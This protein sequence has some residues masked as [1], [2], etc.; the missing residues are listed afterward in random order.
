MSLPYI[1]SDDKKEIYVFDGYISHLSEI[2]KEIT[3]NQIKILC[4]K[5]CEDIGSNFDFPNNPI[6]EITYKPI[7]STTVNHKFKKQNFSN[8]PEKLLILRLNMG[9]VIECC[10]MDNL[11]G[12]LKRLY[13]PTLYHW[14][15]DN[16]PLGLEELS[17]YVDNNFTPCLN[18]LP[19][20]LKE[21]RISSLNRR[22]E[23]S[24]NCDNLPNG[25]EK[26]FICG[27]IDC[28]FNCLPRNLKVLYLGDECAKMMHDLPDGLEELSIRG[29]Y[30][31]LREIFLSAF[32]PMAKL[33]KLI[34]KGLYP[35]SPYSI[36]ELDLQSIPSS[37]EEIVF[38]HNFNQPLDYLPAGIKKI[39]FGKNFNHSINFKNLPTSIEYLEF[40]Y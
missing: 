22:G 9:I 5:S 25:L 15:L 29:T 2:H 23:V 37:V 34:I 27:Y 8:L 7:R 26:L 6:E 4:Y 3:D 16:L 17:L 20:S 40:G 35:N 32:A 21:L 31:C 12:G 11:P 38:D 33:K 24:I 14:E 28:E 1:I 18:F 10:K 39:T 19:E 13:L 30:E 36:S